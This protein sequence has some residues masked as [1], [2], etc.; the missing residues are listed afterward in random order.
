MSLQVSSNEY[1]ALRYIVK[2]SIRNRKRPRSA[3]RGTFMGDIDP[4]IARSRIMSA[5][6]CRDT[7]P[8]LALRSYLHRKGF[9]FRVCVAGLPGRPDIVLPRYRIAVFVDGCF[10]HGHVPCR[11]YLPPI[12]RR[13]YWQPK[14]AANRSR[15]RRQSRELREAGWTVIRV[16]E[17]EIAIEPVLEARLLPLT[18]ARALS[19]GESPSL[20]SRVL[21]TATLLAFAGGSSLAQARR[22]AGRAFA[23]RSG[24]D[25]AKD[26]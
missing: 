4:T 12:S 6:K 17:C 10:W 15:D 3:S 5:C 14:I 2:R 9:R 22:W 20:L 23:R 7:R 26:T 11:A 13:E 21:A 25:G 8:E 18:D 1:S 19:R 16:P 24:K